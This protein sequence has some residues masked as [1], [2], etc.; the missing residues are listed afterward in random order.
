MDFVYIFPLSKKNIQNTKKDEKK[1][2]TTGN[3]SGIISE[4]ATSGR[5]HREP[6]EKTSKKTSK[7]FQK[8]IDKRKAM[9]YN[10]KVARKE[11]RR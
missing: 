4:H 1:G 6:N 8:G 3:E 5:S 10:N 2:L 7:K 11:A 9:W